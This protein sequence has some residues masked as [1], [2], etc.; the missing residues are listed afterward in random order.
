MQELMPSTFL[1][2]VPNDEYDSD[3][4]ALELFRNLGAELEHS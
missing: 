4:E 1:P 2:N 3:Q